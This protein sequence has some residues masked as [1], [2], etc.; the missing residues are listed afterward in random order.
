MKRRQF[1]TLIGGAAAVWPVR[2]RAQQKIWKIGM[3]TAVSRQSFS[4]LYASFIKG[5]RD[6]GHI[7]GNDFTVE[8][9][10]AEEH[11]DRFPE[12]IAELINLKVDLII[13][14]TS[15]AYRHLQQATKTIPIILLYMTDP[16]GSGF[17]GSLNQPGGNITGL[18]SSVDET[19]PKQ[20]ELLSMVVPNLRRI[21]LLGNPGS[22][23]YS[24]AR[25][26]IEGAAANAGLSLTVGEASN[27]EQMDAA[28]KTFMAA[29]VQGFVAAPDAVFFGDRDRL[30]QLAV[31]NNLPSMFSRRE[32]TVAGGLMSYSENLS[33]FFYRAGY[34]VDKIFKGAKPGDLPIQQPTLF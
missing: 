15:P 27:P 18:A 5:M 3:L 11:Y 34:F 24:S 13:T 8:W 14:A 19:A 25:K 4:S 22:Q 26:H 30:V 32:Y 23:A 6:L 33:D 31:Q 7:E 1:I 29:T 10:S 9:R 28:I 2:G 21:G 17:V 20:V 12:L 16:V